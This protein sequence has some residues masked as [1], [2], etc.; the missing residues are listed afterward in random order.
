MI[1]YYA[2]EALMRLDF[3][4]ALKYLDLLI[5]WFERELDKSNPP[6]ESQSGRE[7]N[8]DDEVCYTAADQLVNSLTPEERKKRE[9]LIDSLTPEQM[10]NA[11]SIVNS[12]EFQ[13]LADSLS[14]EQQKLTNIFKSPEQPAEAK[15]V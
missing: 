6:V 11:Q 15:N 10:A 9:K 7:S 4:E 5:D 3:P 8:P 13:E 2:L 1:K 14:P 12:Q